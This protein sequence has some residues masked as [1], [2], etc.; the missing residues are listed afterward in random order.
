MVGAGE[1]RSGRIRCG[2]RD[3]Q[4]ARNRLARRGWSRGRGS[5][6]TSRRRSSGTTP[7]ATARNAGYGD[8]DVTLE[9]WDVAGNY[10]VTHG[11]LHHI[12]PTPMPRPT[13]RRSSL[14]DPTKAAAFWN[15][16]RP[17]QRDPSI[18]LFLPF[19]SLVLPMGG[20]G[21]VAGGKQHRDRA[22]Q[23]L[24]RTARDPA[25]PSRATGIRRK[26]I[27]HKGMKM[28]EKP[29]GGNPQ[30]RT[31]KSNLIAFLLSLAGPGHSGLNAVDFDYTGP[32]TAASREHS[33]SRTCCHYSCSHGSVMA[34]QVLWMLLYL[35]DLRDA[36]CQQV[37]WRFFTI[38][39][40]S[41]YILGVAC[42]IGSVSCCE[43]GWMPVRDPELAHAS[44]TYDPP[45][46]SRRR[47]IR[48]RL[49]RMHGVW[50][51]GAGNGH[52]ITADEPIPGYSNHGR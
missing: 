12:W 7:T 50:C 33:C 19:W 35:A 44:T 21:R 45:A 25:A 8:F 2:L 31:A 16:F 37:V 28:T 18:P 4:L 48:L 14:A 17:K 36:S 20:I 11:V 6:P 39:H 3:R 26:P 1:R 29:A 30:I 41:G 23:A 10:S 13:S 47:F 43:S 22:R 46:I 5:T 42:W 24:E 52:H 9:V 38:A 49:R 27:F 51:R 32:A 34:G 15:P 40:V